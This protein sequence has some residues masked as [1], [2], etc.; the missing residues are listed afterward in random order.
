MHGHPLLY[1]LYFSVRLHIVNLY[2]TPVPL[3]KWLLLKRDSQAKCEVLMKD[4]IWV[5]LQNRASKITSVSRSRTFHILALL[6]FGR[7]LYL[8]AKLQFV[9]LFEMLSLYSLMRASDLQV[10]AEFSHKVDFLFSINTATPTKP[11]CH[12]FGYKCICFLGNLTCMFR[13]EFWWSFNGQLVS[14][15]RRKNVH[16]IL[17]WLHS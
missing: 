16:T 12:A 10:C 2:H 14:R 17:Y 13:S 4:I 6:L 9:S 7:E 11:I 5:N 15:N 8:T 1:R 3:Y